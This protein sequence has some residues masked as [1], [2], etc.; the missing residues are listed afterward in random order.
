MKRIKKKSDRT[1]SF[2]GVE[3]VEDNH[4]SREDTF[5]VAYA[6]YDTLHK[7]CPGCAMGVLSVLISMLAIQFTKDLEKNK[8]MF[9]HEDWMKYIVEGATSAI[10]KYQQTGTTV[11]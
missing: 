10:T 9:D 7:S 1:I 11:Q 3:I 4:I 5:E 8:E 2:E 6:M